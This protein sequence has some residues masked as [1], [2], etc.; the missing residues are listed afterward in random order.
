MSDK[1]NLKKD[2]ICPDCGESIRKNDKTRMIR[3]EGKDQLLHLE[4]AEVVMEEEKREAA[5]KANP[6]SEPVTTEANVDQV[7]ATPPQQPMRPIPNHLS[8]HTP[9]GG[10]AEFPLELTRWVRHMRATGRIVI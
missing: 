10:L 6:V 9:Q 1:L 3:L 7:T 4:C 5:S 2:L 8:R